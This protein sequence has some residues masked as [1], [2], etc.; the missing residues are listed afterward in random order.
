MNYTINRSAAALATLGV[1]VALLA[2]CS[3]D[4]M[5]N[6]ASGGSTSVDVGTYKQVNL[7]SDGSEGGAGNQD[8]GL[9]NPWG[10]AFA[11][12]GAIWVAGAGSSQ[13][14][15]Y[16][17][18][19]GKM[20]TVVVHPS[21]V[22]G[23]VSAPVGLVCN[24]TVQFPIPKK[25]FSQIIIANGGG[26]ISA[27]SRE[28]GSDAEVL[29]DRTDQGAGYTG[30]AIASSNGR[31]FL[32]AANFNAG[33]VDVFTTDFLYARSFTDSSLSGYAPF[34]VQS[35]D[36][37]LWVT[38]AKRGGGDVGAEAKG[39]GLGAVVV[40]DPDGRVIQRFASGG[41]LNAPWGIAKAPAGFG[42]LAGMILIGNFGDGRIN[43]YN[44][45]GGL[46]GQL[47]DQSGNPVS[48]DGLWGLAFNPKGDGRLYFTAG[49]G[50]E[51]HGLFGYL[52]A[53]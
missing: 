53:D 37:E 36:G 4:S 46:V 9:V 15:A 5:T 42:A 6:P 48:I 7:V 39:A 50:E 35:I 49:S 44:G 31:D 23:G 26:T 13:I 34:N 18:D 52:S 16:G 45:G 19:G 3:G 28:L 22:F 40:F 10:I 20:Q 1:A 14:A 25:S 38:F 47:R 27:W 24:T 21:P 51:R 33:S 41:A 30:V 17:A 2:G 29:A 43:V 32:Y 12:D 11:P 8:P